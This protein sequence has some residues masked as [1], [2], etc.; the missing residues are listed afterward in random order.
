MQENGRHEKVLLCVTPPLQHQNIYEA[1]GA[2]DSSDRPALIPISHL[3]ALM[4]GT[5]KWEFKDIVHRDAQQTPS[6]PLNHTKSPK[7]YY[8]WSTARSKVQQPPP[9]ELITVNS[10]TQ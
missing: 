10:S 2:K 4:G 5:K 6:A 8:T 9:T 1:L 3:K 7:R